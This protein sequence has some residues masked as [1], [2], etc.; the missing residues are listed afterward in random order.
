MTDAEKNA[1][2][3]EQFYGSLGEFD[4]RLSKEQSEIEKQR[5]AA[6]GNGRGTG[7]SSSEGAG[8]GADGGSGTPQEVAGGQSGAAGETTG[9]PGGGAGQPSSSGPK[10]PPPEGTPTGV[11]DDVVA[12]QLR[13]AAESEK[14]PELRER[15]WQEYR[16]YKARK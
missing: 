4:K 5:T 2:W 13:E 3:D 14:D 16:K 7:S 1:A 11:D 15:L 12:R 6:A 8:T 10:F 9:G